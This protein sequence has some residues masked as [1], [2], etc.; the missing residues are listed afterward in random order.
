FGEWPERARHVSPARGPGSPPGRRRSP[1]AT[2]VGVI[3]VSPRRAAIFPS[4]ATPLFHHDP[5]PLPPT[6]PPRLTPRPRPPPPRLRR[7]QPAQGRRARAGQRLEP[8]RR[9]D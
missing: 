8:P 7:P 3:L 2:L 5:I 9:P 4:P 1:R 6:P